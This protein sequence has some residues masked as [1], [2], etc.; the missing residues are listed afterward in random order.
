MASGGSRGNAGR[1]IDPNSLASAKGKNDGAW[2]VLEP[3]SG[4]VPD[5]PLEG[6][7]AR[8]SF[9]W[10][11]LWKMPQASKWAELMMADVVALYVR[12]LVEAEQPGAISNT[13]NLVKQ[14]QELLGL[15]TAGLKMQHWVM[16]TGD[17]APEKATGTAGKARA[18]SRARLKVV[19]NDG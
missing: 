12:Y 17:A 14:Y 19:G 8:E 5:F 3:A 9:W 16:P 13:R 1:P 6:V 10:D 7:T 2:T 18:S 11:R 15:S 4:V